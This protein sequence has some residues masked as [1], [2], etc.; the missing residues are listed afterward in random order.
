MKRAFILLPCILVAMA[1]CDN[2]N[3]GGVE[4]AIVRPPTVNAKPTAGTGGNDV[5]ERLPEGPVLYYVVNSTNGPVLMPVGEISGD[6]MLP[7]RAVRDAR[8]FNDRFIAE[9]MRQ[10]NEFVLYREGSRVGTFVVTSATA[11]P[12]NACPP[13]PRASGAMELGAG[14]TGASEFLAIPEAYAPEIR[15]RAGAVPVASRTMQLLAPILAEKM[16]RARRAPLPGNWQRALA[17]LKPFPITTGTEPAYAT[18]FLVGDTLG[19]GADNEG[20]S[21]FYIG[22]PAQ[23]S[24][25]TVFVTY[26]DYRQGGKAAP[27]VIDF[28]DWTRD[29]QPELLLQVY[30]INDVWFEAVGKD[31]QGDWKRIFRDRCEGGSAPAAAQ[32]TT[33]A[34]DSTTRRN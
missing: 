26:Q 30:G 3:W 7:I 16:I 1:G 6:S 12:A 14:A 9:H 18:T 31:N 24:Y 19:R 13:L 32:D 33:A 5:E 27:R 4:V 15:R 22:T 28:L 17:Q 25:D 11:P 23:M 29:D 8:A 2:V 10:G 21:L 20:Y 34:R